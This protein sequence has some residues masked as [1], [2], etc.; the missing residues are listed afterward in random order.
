VIVKHGNPCGAAVATT[1]H[2]AYQR[3]IAGDPGSAYGGVIVLNRRLDRAGAEAIVGQF[4]EAV[5]A[6]GYDDDA[7]AV[8]SA[9]PELRVLD[10]RERR[11][12]AG[13]ELAFHQV[14]GGVLVQD[15]DSS[16]E[17]R[18]DMEVVSARRP[19][20]AEWQAM[21]FAWRVCR[22]VRSDAVVLAR[23]GATVG[24]G[25]GQMSRVDAVRIAL[26]K[27]ALSSPGEAGPGQAGPGEAG[28]KPDG[29][30]LASDAS[31]AFIDAPELALAAGITA[32]IQPGGSV[33]D[34]EV[35]AAADRA[36]AAMVFTALRHFRH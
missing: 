34:P 22:H 35:I 6:C 28:G 3:A 10:D 13:S 30:V 14:D 12:A 27:A 19:T 16:T 29:A 11:H 5:L 21:L 26:E 17:D 2:E 8:L 33:R 18:E 1:A 9:K 23:D 32:I 31:F 25:A 15:R 24:L 36:G 20:D 7:L 4:A